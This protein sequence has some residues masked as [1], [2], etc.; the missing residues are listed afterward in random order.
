VVK[1]TFLVAHRAGN[2]LGRLRR[3]ES[4]GIPLIEADIH[5]F[6]GRLE[7]RHLKTVGPLPILW[8]RWT[9]A[10]PWSP[11]L[12]LDELLAAAGGP[13]ELMLDLKGRDPRLPLLVAQAVADSGAG[14][15][16]TVCSQR[17]ELLDPLDG[18]SDL[19]VVHSVGSA[20]RLEELRRRFARRSLAG[21]SIHRR[22]RDGATVADLRERAGLL[23]SWPVEDLAQ[24]R[25]LEAWGVDGLITSRFEALAP[26]YAPTERMVAA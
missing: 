4:L 22:L 24:A 9:L 21:I 25:Q 5:L 2:E 10:A 18:A 3:A 16:V 13:G 14:R 7:V 19:R 15:R 6:A 23:L 8:D 17:W 20:R 26:V 1:E 11:R 12:L